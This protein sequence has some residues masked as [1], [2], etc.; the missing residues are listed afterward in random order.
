MG[1]ENNSQDFDQR[2]S[3]YKC[4][5]KLRLLHACLKWA[6]YRHNAPPTQ[7][8]QCGRDGRIFGV[9]REKERPQTLFMQTKIDAALVL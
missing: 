6:V 1:L 9:T 8:I 4:I 2:Q 7:C 3:S 5:L